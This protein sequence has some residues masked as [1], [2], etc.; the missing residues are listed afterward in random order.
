VCFVILHHG[1][2]FLSSLFQE[3]VKLVVNCMAGISRSSTSVATYLILKK[4][5]TA[6]EA[7]TQ[8]KKGRDIWPSNPNLSLLAR[9]SNE[10]HGHSNPEEKDFGDVP[11]RAFMKN[12]VKN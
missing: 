2:Y 5:M 9:M 6:Q 12:A 7:L 8:M 4:G 11:I 3:N 1:K 10:K